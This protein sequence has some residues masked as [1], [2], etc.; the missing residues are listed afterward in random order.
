MQIS[1]KGKP[2][3]IKRKEVKE[4][5]NFFAEIL[6]GKKLSNNIQLL[7]VFDKELDEPN[8]NVGGYCE[9]VDDNTRP[10]EFLI[11]LSP[12]MDYEN[13]LKILSHEMTHLKQYARGTLKQTF[14]SQ[15]LKWENRFYSKTMKSPG[16]DGYEEQPWEIEAVK[17][18]QIL[19]LKYLNKECT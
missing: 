7:I 9:W 10:R 17:M 14:T 3:N 16:E 11:E 15:G 5:A 19:L 1:T 12:S 13:T 2:V 8:T 4:A 6:L 18:E